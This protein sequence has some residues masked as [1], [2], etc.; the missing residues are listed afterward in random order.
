[1]IA[2]RLD[3]ENPTAVRVYEAL[4]AGTLR[5]TS[6]G[7]GVVEKHWGEIDGKPVRFLDELELLEVSIVWKG[8]ARTRMIEVRSEPAYVNNTTGST[9]AV[10][11][12]ATPAADPEL[13]EINARLDA[14]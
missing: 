7:F 5:E 2:G 11:W 13:A 10:T 8:A 3:L 9:A 4:L 6:I 14:I 1:M 12:T